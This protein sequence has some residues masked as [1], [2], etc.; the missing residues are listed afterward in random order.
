MATPGTSR[1]ESEGGGGA[2]GEGIITWCAPV[3]PAVS[4]HQEGGGGR[5]LTLCCV[6][7]WA[8]PCVGGSV[9]PY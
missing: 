8:G 9:R 2:E 5:G 7:R 3:E 1:G 4:P 6:V